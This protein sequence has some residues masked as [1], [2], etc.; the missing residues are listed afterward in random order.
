MKEPGKLGLSVIFCEAVGI[1]GTLFTSKAIP[2]WYSG[3]NRPF[4]SPPNWVFGPVW[5]ALYAMMG[6]SLYLVTVQKAPAKQK[7]RAYFFFFAQ[8]LLNFLWSIGFFGLR[9]PMLGLAII[10]SLCLNKL[11]LP[12]QQKD[13]PYKG[14]KPL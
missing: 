9:S 4:F 5:T 6:V 3:L 14:K 7:Q 11:L 10:I 1:V 8:L 12:K 13:T 2:E